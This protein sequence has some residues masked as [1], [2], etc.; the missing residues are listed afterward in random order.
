MALYNNNTHNRILSSNNPTEGYYDTKQVFS[1]AADIHDK[2]EPSSWVKEIHFDNGTLS[3]TFT[4]GA[5]C[6]YGKTFTK[7]E[8]LSFINSSS[9]GRWVNQNLKG[10]PYTIIS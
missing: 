2:R 5:T 1:W 9:K 4:D 6:V 7:A 8:V 10:V 3:V